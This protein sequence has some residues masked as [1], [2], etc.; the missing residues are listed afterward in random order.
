[1]RLL[2]W[3]LAMMERSEDAPLQ[4]GQVDTEAV[5]RQTIL[6]LRPDVVCLQE[7]PGVVPFVETHDMIRANPRSHSGNLAVLVSH[8]LMA[9]KPTF[10]TVT[11][12]AIVVDLPDQEMTVANVHLA[13][14]KGGTDDRLHQLSVTLEAAGH[15]HVVVIGDTN[16]RVDEY[17]VVQSLG[18]A[19]D[20]PPKPTWDGYRNGFRGAK[21]RFRAYFTR[22]L[23]TPG[24]TIVDQQVLDGAT[25]AYDHSFHMSDHFPLQVEV[26]HN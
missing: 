23:T 9:S 17:E 18:L 5:V 4:W 2:T 12:T 24:L 14:G 26:R 3:N 20:L 22:A 8:Q 7:L 16:L 13:P 19:G 21:G 1:M 15:D 6:D 25:E 11:R 10:K